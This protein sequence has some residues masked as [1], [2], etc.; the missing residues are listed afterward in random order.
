ML[1]LNWLEL[2]GVCGIGTVIFILIFLIIEIGKEV[3][4]ESLEPDEH[5]YDDC[6]CNK[7]E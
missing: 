1:E 6:D 7:K 2:A 5:E 3:L 4:S